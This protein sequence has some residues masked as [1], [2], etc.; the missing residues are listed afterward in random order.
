ML[1]SRV[2]R[3]PVY[4]MYTLWNIRVAC[5]LYNAASS[6]KFKPLSTALR[7]VL[8]IEAH[9]TQHANGHEVLCYDAPADKCVATSKTESAAYNASQQIARNQER[10]NLLWRV[11]SY[12][13]TL[14][15][16]T[17]SSCGSANSPT[18]RRSSLSRPPSPPSLACGG[19]VG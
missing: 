14:V 8:V 15:R 4:R 12:R 5:V 10:H 18:L 11:V 9:E 19:L 2:C 3:T 16:K 1:A 17:D 7:R 6:G 13:A